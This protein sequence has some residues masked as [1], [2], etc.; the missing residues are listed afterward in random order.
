MKAEPFEVKVP[1]ADLDDLRFRLANTRWADDLG[2]RDWRYGVER[3]W[4]ADML[5]Y[6]CTDYDWCVHERTINRLANFRVVI[7]GVPLHVVHVRS[8]NPGA[9]PL[10]L[11]HGWPWTFMDFQALIDPLSDPGSHRGRVLDSFDV[12]IPSLPGFGFSTPLTQTGLAVPRLAELFATLMTAVLGYQRYAV[13]GG[14]WGAVISLQIAHAH[15]QQVI[16]AFAT[17]PFYPGLDLAAITDEQ[18]ASDEQWML[19]RKAETRDLISSHFTVQSLD[20]QTLAYAL[21]DSPAGT[22]AWLWERRRA[23]SDCDGDLLSAYTR[24]FLCTLASIYWLT[25]TIGTSLRIYWES[26]RFDPFRRLHD[27]T[28]AVEVPA[29][30]AIHPKE[31]MLVPRSVAAA[32]TN[33]QRWSLM[34][35]GGHFGFAE[36]PGALVEEFRT[37]FRPLR[38]QMLPGT[39]FAT[40]D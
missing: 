9:V 12:I 25:R 11:L 7:D 29:G 4:L 24:D 10:L 37:F 14:D 27:R 1:E 8:P 18:Y 2:N 34:P 15:P 17:I 19:A 38:P 13:G 22:A 33:L 3:E 39:I 16:G 5:A 28:P 26:Y 32:G 20:P 6:W 35:R 31:V 23:W 21:V 30:F 40:P 36:Q